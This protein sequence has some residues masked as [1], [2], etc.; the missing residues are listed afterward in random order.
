[1]AIA[2]DVTSAGTATA[3]SP[4][5]WNHTC[6]GSNLVLIVSIGVYAGATPDCSAVTY[7]GVAMTQVG[8][9]RTQSSTQETMWILVNPATG[10]NQISATFSGTSKYAAGTAVSYTG[11]VQSGQPNAVA[12]NT[13]ATANPSV[14]VTTTVDNCWVVGGL[15]CILTSTAGLTV[16]QDDI[17]ILSLY[18]TN[19]EDTNAPKTPLGNQVVN[20]TNASTN[21]WGLQACSIAPFVATGTK[22]Q[23][24]IG[25]IWKASTTI[26][27]NIGDVW[28]TVTSIKQNIGDLWKTIF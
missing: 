18:Y 4:L 8:S 24:N 12:G 28:K 25:D 20:W 3:T 5:A 19:L 15:T 13:G 2:Y 17:V 1:M 7:N 11:C 6:T 14:T 10:S 26:Q 9:D 27:I 16:R 23:I 21:Q 22:P